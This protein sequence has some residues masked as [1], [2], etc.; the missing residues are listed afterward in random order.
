MTKIYHAWHGFPSVR[1]DFDPIRKQLFTPIIF[2][3]PSYQWARFLAGI[4]ALWVLCWV[5]LFMTFSPP[6]APSSTLDTSHQ[7]DYFQASYNLIFLRSANKMVCVFSSRFLLSSYLWQPRT[8]AV[9]CV[10]L[11]PLG[12][13]TINL[14]ITIDHAGH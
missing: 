13:L 5:V 6:V 1:A 3:L 11:G 9:D 12:P 2:M 4:V 10:V 7:G 8:M 14:Y